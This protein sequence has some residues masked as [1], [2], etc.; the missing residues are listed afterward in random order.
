MLSKPLE[1]I[2]LADIESLIENS[3]AEGKT[4]E[5]KQELRIGSDADKRE[6][7]AD[8]SSFANTTGGDIIFGV[9]EADG[10]PK[11]I[12][13][14]DIQNA[15][16]LKLKIG[17]ILQT[18]VSPRLQ[19]AL[20]FV[21]VQGGKQVVIVRVGQSTLAPHRVT[22]SDKFWG[23]NS[24][25]KYP[26]DVPELRTAF[27]RS[28][29]IEERILQFKKEQLENLGGLVKGRVVLHIIPHES[30][31][32]RKYVDPK[33]AHAIF[34]A[35]N[36]ASLFRPLIANGWSPRVNLHGFQSYSGNTEDDPRTYVQI[37]KNGALE[38]VE[39]SI[40][41][42]DV[43]PKDKKLN[44]RAIENM[45]INGVS[46]YLRL[47]QKLDVNPPFYVFIT[48][49]WVRG[50]FVRPMDMMDEDRPINVDHLELPEA[51]IDDFGANVAAALK[52]SF[53]AVW[54]AAGRLGSSSYDTNGEYI[55]H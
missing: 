51:V 24:A 44:M 40:I 39:S 28:M 7:L 43:E 8:V 34:I 29:T 14:I 41:N 55:I 12:V 35:N 4:I 18:G 32:T 46:Q 49:M 26:L 42:W 47:L 5:Y 2:A 17:G 23:R 22:Q 38:A 27:T 54:H 48:L 9:K 6:F 3:V 19:Y 53:D 36:G 45:L 21:P 31:S 16:E 33:E 10:V 20:S 30:F 25:G 13:G 37:F 15:D 52:H 1:S 50:H 11:K